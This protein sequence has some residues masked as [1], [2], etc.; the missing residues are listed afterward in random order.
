MSQR[1]ELR[2]TSKFDRRFRQLDKDL[3]IRVAKEILKLESDPLIG[4]ALHGVLKGLRSL[5]IGDYRVIYE[6]SGRDIVLHWVEHRRRA[7]ER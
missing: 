4:K 2:A 6:I 3:Q 1:Y 5:R 7:Y